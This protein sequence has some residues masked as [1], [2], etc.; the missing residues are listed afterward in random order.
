MHWLQ[1]Q[2]DGG[3]D[4]Q[5]LQL[6]IVGFLAILGEGSVL[7]NA[8]VSTLSRWIFLPRLIPAPQALMRPAR[9]LELEPVPGFVSGVWSGNDRDN[10]NHIASIV[11]DANELPPFS[12]RVVSIQRVDET[13]PLKVRT[14]A[15]LT[16]VA[17]IGC[18][19]SILLL[20]LSIHLRDGMSILATV[21]LSLLSTLIG[22]GNFWTLRL[23]ERLQDQQKKNQESK[24][25]K[26]QERPH[27]EERPDEEKNDRE[28]YVPPGDLVIRYPRG[29]FLVVRCHENVA[30][31]LYFAP[32]EIDYYLKHAWAYRLLSLVGTMMLMGGVVCLANA[33]I[34]SQIAWAGSYML[35]G[36]SYW[37]VAAL[38]GKL[39]WDTSAYRV[40]PEALSDS[41]Q[42]ETGTWYSPS[43]TFTQALWKAIVVSKDT[44][45]V[46]RNNAC[47]STTMWDDWLQMAKSCSGDFKEGE[48]H[49]IASGVRTW[50][51]PSWDPQKYFTELLQTEARKRGVSHLARHA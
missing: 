10:V 47:P 19:L 7:A 31:E 29:T 12:V 6:D 49:P 51:I 41:I 34:E 39:H 2:E 42:T 40:V 36:S 35:L 25:G 3:Y 16:F 15:P 45:W 24:H 26:P 27:A 46:H 14:F 23:P 37:I 20:V 33:K 22:L 43:Q 8:Q 48:A 32:V 4:L 13:K 30:R 18:S 1:A 44:G 17:V 11:C 28:D 9:P 21:L 50:A 38:P 5:A